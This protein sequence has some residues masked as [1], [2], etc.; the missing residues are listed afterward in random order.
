MT[1]KLLTNEVYINIREI[2][3]KEE[4]TSYKYYR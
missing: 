4:T 2:K 3:Q 1:F